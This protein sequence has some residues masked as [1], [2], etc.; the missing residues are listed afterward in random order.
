MAAK[1][2]ALEAER[3]EVAI[4]AVEGIDQGWTNPKGVEDDRSGGSQGADRNTDLVR[5]RKL[6]E[7]DH[8][9]ASLRLS[10]AQLELDAGAGSS[11]MEAQVEAG[12]MAVLDVVKVRL[13]DGKRRKK[14]RRGNSKGDKGIGEPS[15]GNKAAVGAQ[16]DADAESSKQHP[17][18]SR[19]AKAAERSKNGFEHPTSHA[20]D[21][22]S[23]APTPAP[24]TSRHRHSTAVANDRNRWFDLQVIAWRLLARLDAQRGRQGRAERW[25]SMARKVLE[26]EEEER[27]RQQDRFH[28]T[29]G[30]DGQAHG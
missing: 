15:N 11:E 8:D 19:E 10:I 26:E 21:S 2:R 25:E 27:V 30:K 18:S 20:S 24:F 28:E 12:C 29:V 16:A 5:Q 9:I 17:T 1:V 14:G 3:E 4:K 13:G 7:L 6:S 23:S 22:P